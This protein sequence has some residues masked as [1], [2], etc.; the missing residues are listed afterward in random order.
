MSDAVTNAEVEDVLSSIRRLV[1]EDRRPLNR[2]KADVAFEDK[3]V[4]TPSLRVSNDAPLMDAYKKQDDAPFVEQGAEQASDA[5]A[6]LLG[7][8]QLMSDGD[9]TSD[10]EPYAVAVEF[11]DAGLIAYEPTSDDVADVDVS[12][13]AE[14]EMP[15]AVIPQIHKAGILNLGTSELVEGGSDRSG[16]DRLSAK[17]AALETAVNRIPGAWDSDETEEE[18]FVVPEPLAMAW[19]DDVD[20][21][22]TGTPLPVED[23]AEPEDTSYE[24]DDHTV[25][26]AKYADED[27][28]D[29]EDQPEMPNGALNFG[30]EEYFDEAML[31]DLVADIVRSELQGA[32]GER[33]TRNVRKLVR[34]EIHRALTAQE[35]E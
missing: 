18:S 15:E 23:A 26:D 25:E 19:E 11:Q 22:A 9:V 30:S 17:I 2:L 33:I 14:H 16:S 8:D 20:L 27:A 10:E 13:D 34:R 12:W 24:K 29:D 35:L 1:S 32:L 21:D 7:S 28:F 3:L 31:R 5:P 4:L 6:E